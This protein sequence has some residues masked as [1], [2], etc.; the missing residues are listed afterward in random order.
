MTSPCLRIEPLHRP[1]AGAGTFCIFRTDA[2]RRASWT[3]RIATRR[4]V[5]SEANV[6]RPNQTASLPQNCRSDSDASHKRRATS[7]D[8]P[9]SGRVSRGCFLAG[10][11]DGGV[12]FAIVAAAERATGEWSSTKRSLCKIV[13][14][15]L[16]GLGLSSDSATYFGTIVIWPFLSSTAYLI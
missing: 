2:T 11:A 5:N 8:H 13:A 6:E 16:N 12:Q 7:R 4:V 1:P 15:Q 10:D 3:T 14:V 9:S